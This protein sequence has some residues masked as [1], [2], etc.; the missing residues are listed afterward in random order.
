MQALHKT[1]SI[2]VFAEDSPDDVCANVLGAINRYLAARA[3][4][5]L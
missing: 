2:V 1:T 3:K 5:N 4:A